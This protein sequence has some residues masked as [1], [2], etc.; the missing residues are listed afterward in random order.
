M[1]KTKWSTQINLRCQEEWIEM[2]DAKAAELGLDRSST[3]RMI[4]TQFIQGPEETQ[5]VPQGPKNARPEGMDEMKERLLGLEFQ[6]GM[7]T[8]EAREQKE[9][10]DALANLIGMV[11][12]ESHQ[13]AG[14]DPF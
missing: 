5:P 4:C 14:R 6:I 11:R 13:L 3:I 7:L 10:N 2:V 1:A 9:R 8:A 12:K